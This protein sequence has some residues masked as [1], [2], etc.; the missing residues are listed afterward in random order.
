MKEIIIG[1]SFHQEERESELIERA[2]SGDH[3]AFSELVRRHRAKAQGWANGLAQDPFL[4]EDIVQEALLKAFIHLGT[5]V[6]V[7][8]FLPWL[9][10]IVR[11]QAM[12][13]LRRGGPYRH[14][15]PFTSLANRST[16]DQIQVDWENIES[17]MTYMMS[18]KFQ[19]SSAASN[20]EEHI[21]RQETFETILN[22]FSCLKPRERGIFEA[23][24]FQQLSPQ[25]IA[26]LFDMTMSSVY[27]S[28]ARTRQKLQHERIRVFIQDHLVQRRDKNS[29]SKKI[30]ERPNIYM[31][32]IGDSHFLGARPSVTYCLWGLLQYTDKKHLSLAEVNGLTGQAFSINIMK[33]TVHIGGPFTLAA[34]PSFE[35]LLANLGFD[36]KVSMNL[37]TQPTAVTDVLRTV[38]QSIDRGAPVIVWDL[39]H[40]EFGLV[41]GYDDDEQ[42]LAALDKLQLGDVAYEQIGRGKT[43][44][45][46]IIAIQ[47]E[48]AIDRKAAL[49]QMI[50]AVLEHGY[51]EGTR[52]TGDGE[53][54]SG[55]AAYD[56]WMEAFQSGRIVP[57]FNAYNTVVYA[58][59]RQY[60]KQFLHRLCDDPDFIQ[61]RELLEA[62]SASYEI[63][64][65][66]LQELA[67]L[68]PFPMGGDPMNEQ[69]VQ[70]AIFLLQE[71][72]QAEKE[73]LYHL[74]FWR[75]RLRL[76]PP[77]D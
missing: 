63:T 66:A 12:M 69:Q 38:H 58:E 16:G 36:F 74:A 51:T 28:L 67:I 8:R 71:A 2:Q 34:E 17:I 11:N 7:T 44:E 18:A 21:V 48:R 24:F 46:S 60:A 62:A 23:Y 73:G 72:K 33:E 22:L 47:E 14:E 29:S 13:K 59:L 76:E 32:R 52:N 3:D 50:D 56:A 10:R 1:H 41:Y 27:K 6:D 53:L 54:A 5:L 77:L 42:R 65:K 20:P 4:A 39:F 37:P 75:D 30:L 68:F 40:A 35:K 19:E 49:L 25:E 57:F 55:L 45:I 43:S 15:Q 26:T 61:D 64:A 31:Q 70:K 9:H